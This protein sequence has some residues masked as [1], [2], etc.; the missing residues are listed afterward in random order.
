MLRFIKGAIGVKIL[1]IRYK[2]R[3]A[4]PLYGNRSIGIA[5]ERQRNHIRIPRNQKCEK[6]TPRC[7]VDDYADM[8]RDEII[9]LIITSTDV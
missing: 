4:Y 9:K 7:V 1:S 2:N 6:E 8:N 3:N 5:N